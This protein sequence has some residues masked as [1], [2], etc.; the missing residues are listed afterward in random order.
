MNDTGKEITILKLDIND[1]FEVRVI[2]DMIEKDVSIPMQMIV[3]LNKPQRSVENMESMLKS[4][5]TLQ[6]KG[7]SIFD[8][9]PNQKTE[10]DNLRSHA[11]YKKFD[12]TI[13]KHASL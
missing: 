4:W 7:Y 10:A 1:G 5:K 2:A 9:N 8:Y 11:Y 12:I 13:L 6:S 3:K